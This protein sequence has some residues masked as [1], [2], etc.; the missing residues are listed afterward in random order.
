METKFIGKVKLE[1]TTQ[2]Y[3]S[4]CCIGYHFKTILL[5]EKNNFV[6]ELKDVV[7]TLS[8]DKDHAL[9]MKRE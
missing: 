8:A 3:Y 1:M 2:E 9:E 7:E 6:N 5:T 4:L